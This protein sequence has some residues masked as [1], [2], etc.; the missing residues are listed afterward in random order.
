MKSIKAL[1]CIALLVLPVSAHASAADE[2]MG[3]GM[4]AALAEYVGAAI[5][6][7]GFTFTA[8]PFI[9]LAGED[10]GPIEIVGRN[11]ADI[12]ARIGRLDGDG[13]YQDL[14]QFKS[15]KDLVSTGSERGRGAIRFIDNL[16]V[17]PDERVM[18]IGFY[19]FGAGIFLKDL[20]EAYTIGWS[21]RSPDGE[22]DPAVEVRDRGDNY[23][24][25][26]RAL[27][28]SGVGVGVISIDNNNTGVGISPDDST[29]PTWL[30]D[31]AT[32]ALMG[33]QG[34]TIALDSGAANSCKGTSS[35]T[36]TSAKTISTTCIGT[37]D[38][39]HITPSSDPSGST[40]AYCWY[41]N[42]QNGVSFDVD[43]DQANDGNFAWDIVKE[44]P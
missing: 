42:I 40:A 6:D 23:G 36:G 28:A 16:K 25:R 9:I 34:A 19:E 27:G 24:L 35:F 44:K 43:C 3:L 7:S 12:I 38:I 18:E 15:R 21:F 5:G 2:L 13:D 1:I 20:F 4:P 31:R 29:T 10:A 8:D 11:D 41:T 32:K 39:V 22:H 14:I 26:F 30:F 37:N 17:D 33:V